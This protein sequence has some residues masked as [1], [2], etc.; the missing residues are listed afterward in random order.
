MDWLVVILVIIAVLFSLALFVW[1]FLPALL[2][3]ILRRVA[4]WFGLKKL[5]QFSEVLLDRLGKGSD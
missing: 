5:K 3:W 1:F 2:A 4:I